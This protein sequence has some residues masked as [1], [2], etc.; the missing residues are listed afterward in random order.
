MGF[1]EDMFGV[2]VVYGKFKYGVVELIFIGLFGV[3]EKVVRFECY[4]K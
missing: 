3:I 1:G 4:F 2:Y